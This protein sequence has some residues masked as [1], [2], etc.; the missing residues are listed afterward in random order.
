M[1]TRRLSTLPTPVPCQRPSGT[2][3][4]GRRSANSF[5]GTRASCTTNNLAASMSSSSPS[6]G[7]V[8]G[9][10]NQAPSATENEK[11]QISC[12]APFTQVKSCLRRPDP[13]YSL[14][15]AWPST[16]RSR[17][18]C[19][20]TDSNSQGPCTDVVRMGKCTR[21]WFHVGCGTH[22]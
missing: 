7:R 15:T 11:D 10:I 17:P 3:P 5:P 22:G 18:T 6:P 4:R 21:C 8:E 20:R 19:Q 9:E 14:V 12:K 16:I 2:D 13:F 1:P